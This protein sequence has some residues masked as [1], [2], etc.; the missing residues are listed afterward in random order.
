MFNNIY[1]TTETV[2][3]D[4]ILKIQLNSIYI[5]GIWNLFYH[6]FSVGTSE[7]IIIINVII[8]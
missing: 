1:S 5:I 4:N 7:H 2:V 8:Y 3:E 6:V